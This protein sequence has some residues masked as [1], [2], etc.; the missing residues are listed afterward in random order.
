ML[1]TFDDIL[2]CCASAS[3]MNSSWSPSQ[4]LFFFSCLLC[5]RDLFEKKRKGETTLKFDDEKGKKG[6]N[7]KKNEN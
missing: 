7:K 6:L 5:Q 3:L 4:L 2:A 1:E